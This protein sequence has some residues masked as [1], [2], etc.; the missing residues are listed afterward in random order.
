MRALVTGGNGFLG[1]Y[2]VEQLLARGDAVRVVG[3]NAY[4]EL[5]ALGVECHRADLSAGDDVGAALRGC[6]AV[7][8]VAARAGV[9]GSWGE[10]FRQNVVATQH[11]LDSAVR[12]GVAKFIYTSSPSVVFGESDLAGVDERQP[13]PTR[14]LA[15]YPH[16]KA[17][18]EQW[19][20]ARSDILTTALRPHLIWGPRDPHIVP[21]LVQRA[22]AGRLPQIGDGSNLVDV[23]YVENAA[24]AHVLAADA[25]AEGSPLNGRPYFVSQDQPVALW[26]FVADL[27]RLAG[28]PAIR[29]SLPYGV[30]RVAAGLIEDAYSFFDIASEPPLTRLVVAQMAMSH[31]FDTSAAR[32]DFGYQATISVE[33][34]LRRTAV[35]VRNEG[36]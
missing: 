1:R 16:T 2:I 5:A 27:L 14:Y 35:W 33:E 22:R 31:W 7:F 25:L 30:A 32:R 28:A 29:R 8:H 11:I 34:G 6:D 20:L 19:V 4:P 18:A 15:P 3:R 10:F 24:A 21:R 12:A 17:I 9:W 23:I 26:E 13:F 36:I